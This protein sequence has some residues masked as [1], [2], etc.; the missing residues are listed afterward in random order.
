MD[1]D[2]YQSHWRQ[3]VPPLALLETSWQ[4]RSQKGR[5]L[6]CGIY[7]TV[8]GLEVRA[9]FGD[10]DLIRSQYAVEITKAREVAAGWK[11]AALAK[12]NFEVIE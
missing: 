7:K 11:A 8:V 12:G 1:F 5:M 9:S 10:D 6:M 3:E 2:P 4:M